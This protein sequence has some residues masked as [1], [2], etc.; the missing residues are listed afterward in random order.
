[1]EATKPPSSRNVSAEIFVVC[2]GFKAP[3]RID[4][5]FLDPKSVFA[6]LADPTP[7]NEAKVFNPEIKKRKRDGYEEGNW[8]QFKEVPASEFIQVCTFLYLWLQYAGKPLYY[9]L[10]AC[11]ERNGPARVHVVYE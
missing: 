6:E 3:K 11:G 7:N 5:K 4:P 9:G 10:F 2:Q 1:M 8:T